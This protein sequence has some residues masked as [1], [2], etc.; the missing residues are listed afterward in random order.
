MGGFQLF[1]G[2]FGTGHN[3]MNHFFGIFLSLVPR[4]ISIKVRLV[5]N[6]ADRHAQRFHFFFCEIIFHVTPFWVPPNASV[7]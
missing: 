6:I 4:N 7:V 1:R 2:R 5:E 3:A